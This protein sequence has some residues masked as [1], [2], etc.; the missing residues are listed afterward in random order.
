[1]IFAAV[2]E[3]VARALAPFTPLLVR[4]RDRTADHAVDQI[5]D[6]INAKGWAL[7]K[8]LWR[9][10]RP[11]VASDP[12]L[13]Q[14]VDDLA[15]V[16]ADHADPAAPAAQQAF[17]RQLERALQDDPSLLGELARLL[18]ASAQAQVNVAD[19]LNIGVQTGSIL[20]GTVTGFGKRTDGGP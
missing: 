20:G 3:A 4:V 5:G 1:M 7:A 8:D 14:A 15:T 9:R 18:T 12:A 2:A 6:R 17:H 10:L 11:R 19:E 13:K 16:Q